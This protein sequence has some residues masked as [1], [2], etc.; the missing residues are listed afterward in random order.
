MGIYLHTTKLAIDPLDALPG[1]GERVWVIE[2]A[3]RRPPAA[4]LF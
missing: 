1:I 4:A 3:L 2:L